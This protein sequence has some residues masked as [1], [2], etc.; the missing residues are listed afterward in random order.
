MLQKLFYT[1]NDLTEQEFSSLDR[2]VYKLFIT[3]I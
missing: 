1:D 2:D 3:E